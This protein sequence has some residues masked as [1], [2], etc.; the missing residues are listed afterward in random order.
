MKKFLLTFIFLGMFLTINSCRQDDT[1]LS[2]D[3]LANLRIIQDTRINRE[4]SSQ[5]NKKD[6][7][8]IM[9]IT[10]KQ[11]ELVKPPK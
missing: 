9:S 4:S 5:I 6:S 10:F 3:D 11:D 7:T 2:N 8:I 1:V